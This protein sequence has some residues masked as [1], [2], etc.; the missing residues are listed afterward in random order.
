MKKIDFSTCHQ[1][2]PYEE[3]PPGALAPVATIK[4]RKLR[5]YFINLV[6]QDLF[7]HRKKSIKTLREERHFKI[8]S[9]MVLGFLNPTSQIRRTDITT[10]CMQLRNQLE[11]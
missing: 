5:I 1:P 8:C 6:K 9:G 3:G 10:F 7:T 2:G 4:G 11:M